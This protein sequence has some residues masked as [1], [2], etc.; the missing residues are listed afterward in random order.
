MNYYYDNTE[1]VNKF[2]GGGVVEPKTNYNNPWI[3]PISVF[4][5]TISI[6]ML[7]EIICKMMIKHKEIKKENN[8]ALKNADSN[9]SAQN[10]IVLPK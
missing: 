4:I 8:N 10:Q 6:L 7:K 5:T 2:S 9:S 1:F 3:F